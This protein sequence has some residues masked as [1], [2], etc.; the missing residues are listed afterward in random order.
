MIVGTTTINTPRQIASA[1]A[2]AHSGVMESLRSD[3]LRRLWERFLAAL[4]IAWD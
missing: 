4:G 3:G 1:H 2:D